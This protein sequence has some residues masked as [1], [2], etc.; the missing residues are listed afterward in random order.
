MSEKTLSSETVFEGRLLKVERL[1]VELASG[2]KSVRE[3]VRHPGAAAVLAR[4]PDGRFVFVRQFR[5]P[6][7]RELVETVA[8]TMEEGEPPA[9]CAARELREETGCKADRLVK[10]GVI[11][12]APGY[13]D[14]RL[15][16]YHADLN[17]DRTE[18][19]TDEDESIEIVLLD[20]D[21]VDEMISNGEIGDA[22]TLAAWLL[23]RKKMGSA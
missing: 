12:P 18:L 2:K 6:L 16:V 10:L 22:K 9:D 5:K 4:A 14:E 23:Y 3:I 13:T 7:E 1:E 17:K 19:R 20:E 11:F 21:K 15:H 8:G